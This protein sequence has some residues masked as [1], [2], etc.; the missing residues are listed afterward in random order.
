[1]I[2]NIKIPLLKSRDEISNKSDYFVN[3]NHSFL[4]VDKFLINCTKKKYTRNQ[5]QNAVKEGNVLVNGLPVK[6]NYR[7]KLFDKVSFFMIIDPLKS[8]KLIPEN[9]PISIIYEDEDLIII[10]KSPGMIIHPA[11]GNYNGTLVNSLVYY[12]NS[13]KNQVCELKDFPGLVHRL[14]KDTSGILVVAK[15]E[16]SKIHLSQQF[17]NRTINRLYIA[18]VWGNFKENYGSINGNIGRDLKNRIKMSVFIDKSKGKPAITHYRV[19]ERFQ[20]VTLLECKLET[21]RTHQIRAHMNY[22]GHPLFNDKRYG[23]EKILRGAIFSKYR[24]FVEN[25]FKILPRQALHAKSLEFIHPKTKKNIFF[26]SELPKDMKLVI[27]KWENYL[28]NN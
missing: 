9:I 1:M 8:I 2:E 25:C 11:H 7:L 16:Y 6:S 18:L 15:N 26:D 24:Q 12:F 22:I 27:K 21:G 5:I 28:K 4:R 13:I 19:L 14:D 17:F 3:K 23:G 10:N 20:Y